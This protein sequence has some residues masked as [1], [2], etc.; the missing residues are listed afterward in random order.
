ML[1][2]PPI[3]RSSLPV[4]LQGVCWRQRV[5]EGR[6]WTNQFCVVYPLTN[7]F[8]VVHSWSLVW[9]LRAWESQGA[10]VKWIQLEPPLIIPLCPSCSI[11]FLV[12]L[13]ASTPETLPHIPQKPNIPQWPWPHCSVHSE[14]GIQANVRRGHRQHNVRFC[15]I[16]YITPSCPKE[17]IF[18]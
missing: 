11:C 5:R 13:P 2:I 1:G 14:V 6:Y 4:L 15:Y 3:V 17:D 10:L 12:P 16:P 8:C 18:S 7:Q 9:L